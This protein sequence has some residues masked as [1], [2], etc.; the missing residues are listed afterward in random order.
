MVSFA[1]LQV[2]EPLMHALDLPDWTLKVVVA[3]LA[4]GF[5]ITSAL[6]W[7]FDLKTTGVERTPAAAP[8]GGPERA[9]G[10]ARAR[11]AV[12]LLGIGLAA[13]TPGVAYF[14]LRRPAAAHAEPPPGERIPIAVADFENDTGEPELDALSGLLIT[15]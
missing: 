15:S 12:L 1:V 5:P 9:P 4:L 6:A 14:F 2:A 8:P 11:L 3:A 7:V 10:L 13:A